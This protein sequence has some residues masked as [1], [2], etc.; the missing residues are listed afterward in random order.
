MQHEPDLPEN[1]PVSSTQNEETTPD[2]SLANEDTTAVLS[3]ED[4]VTDWQ[5]KYI[6]LYSEFDNFRKRTARERIDLI[7]TAGQDVIISLLPVLDDFDRSLK[8]METAADVQSV[9]EGVELIAHK[10][11]T[12]LQ[13]KGLEPM[14]A[15]GEPFNL[16]FHEAITNIPAKSPEEAGLVVDELEKG[17][18]L[19]DKVIRFAKVVV[20]Q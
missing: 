6:R 16:D 12:T 10:M 13:N 11:R 8:A 7:K 15:L 20:A 1:E 14:N 17:Y 5:D 18:K 19:V 9:K 3:T 2:T 4:A